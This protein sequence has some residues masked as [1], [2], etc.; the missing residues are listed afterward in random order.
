MKNKVL[1]IGWD[2]ADW[3]VIS[4]LMD[5]GKMPNL[6]R[7]VSNG[8][9]GNL[10]TLYPVLSP[11]LWTSIATGKRAYKHGIHGFSEPDLVGGVRP[12]TNLGRKTKAIW[13]IL[14]Q[15]GLKS[16]VVGWWPS[17]PVEPIN[18]VMVSNHFQGAVATADKSWPMKPGTVYPERL[19]EPLKEFRIHP[20]EILAEQILPFVPK[21]D[22]IDQDNDTRLAAIAKTLAEC[23]SVHAAS[24]ALMQL[25]DW[26]FM[27][28]YHDAIDHFCHGFM[29]YHPPKLE[30]IPE[31]DYELYKEVVNGA[32]QFH[33]L[34]L[35]T[36]MEIAGDDTNIIICS[37][38]GFHP[39]HLRPMELPNESAGPAEEHRHFGMFAAMGPA[40]KKDQLVFG[41]SLLDITPTILQL[42]G[43]PVG[44]DM[45]G[46]P[47]LSAFENPQQIP[48]VE[49]WDSISGDTGRHPDNL[50]VDPVDE[51]E[52]LKQLIDLGYIDELDNNK[53]KAISNTI[54]ELRYNLARDYI[55][56]N[57]QSEAIPILQELWK[58][59][60]S[61]ARFG[62]V[63][64]D[65]FL[66][67]KQLKLAKQTLKLIIK[68]KNKLSLR[69][70]EELIQFW[71]QI[72]DKN[73]LDTLQTFTLKK[74]KKQAGTNRASI[75]FFWGKLF[76]AERKYKQALIEFDKAE[77]VQMHNI[78]S[79]W[80]KKGEVFLAIRQWSAAA[81]CFTQILNI[82]PVN[83]Y[84][85]QGLAYS[86]F[87]QA[88]KQQQALE[89][90][91]SSLGLVFHNA[92]AHYLCGRILQRAGK[93]DDA[94][95]AYQ[96]AVSINPVYP[97]VYR[98]LAYIFRNKKQ[99]EKKAKQQDDLAAAAI[100]RL[101]ANKS[102]KQSVTLHN[103]KLNPI[104][105]SI[106]LSMGQTE[107]TESLPPLAEN[108]IVI[109]SGLPRSGTS[110]MM[111]MLEAGGLKVLID[112][113]RKSDV[114]NKKGYYEFEQ[115]KVQNNDN[116]WL[117]E[118]IGHA[119][120][121]VAQ[122]LPKLSTQ[123][124]YRIIFMERPLQEIIESQKIMLIRRGKKGANLSDKKLAQ[125]YFSQI[126]NVKS[127]LKGFHSISSVLSVNY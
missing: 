60:H 106:L 121:M 88:D 112:G 100:A 96:T 118:A 35:G 30:W 75:A 74:L 39:D 119:V 29:K 65:C 7:F 105:T 21:A 78:P 72:E 79:L 86:Y 5:A 110:M 73:K 90:I 59:N 49:S 115:S 124:R 114:D 77:S 16:N 17:H 44:K 43:L 127:L 12:V 108:E 54:K 111:Q 25:E 62:I 104:D 38:H 52:A 45:D 67:L 4:P 27:A 42:F 20:T 37:D 36:L 56:A 10:S 102:G 47:L 22:D 11:M 76:F 98:R 68:Y 103:A 19:I 32:Y 58:D 122:L 6:E 34:M 120:K 46:R 14:N 99:N 3:K 2:A 94:I 125:A 95:N 70:K 97:G 83:A 15:S 116:L 24:T 107:L 50:Q 51:S 48:P 64:F 109:V 18:G 33:D 117:Q 26:D 1:L 123:Y 61:E 81:E 28:V 82:D 66:T 113:K 40:F 13:N 80:Q 9:M 91:S 31:Q 8:V 101:L 92:R 63:L 53:E 89:A 93:I 85:Q 84:A 126:N 87:M 71:Q 23:A 69:A 41:A 55:D 57:K